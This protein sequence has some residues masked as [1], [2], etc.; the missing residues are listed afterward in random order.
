MGRTVELLRVAGRLAVDDVGVVRVPGVT[1]LGEH[2]EDAVGAL[3]LE[4]H[5]A[6]LGHLGDRGHR[7]D[8][9]GD[10]LLEDA[11]LERVGLDLEGQPQV[12]GAA[13]DRGAGQVLGRGVRLGRDHWSGH[14]GCDSEGCHESR[15]PH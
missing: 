8:L 9:A 1:E 10:P 12:V 6:L 15:D 14:N 3:V 13:L 7:R 4:V 11:L 2:D 5:V